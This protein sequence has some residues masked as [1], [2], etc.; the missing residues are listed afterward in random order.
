MMQLRNYQETA[1]TQLNGWWADHDGNP[2]IMLPTGAGKSIVIAAF[3]Q[4]SIALWPKTRIAIICS[5]KEL[6]EQDAAKIKALWPDA[7]MGVVCAA[8]GR[9]EFGR[10]VTVASILSIFRRQ[11]SELGIIDLIVVDEAHLINHKDQGSYRSFIDRQKEVNPNLR[12]IGLTATPYRLGHG[13]ITDGDALFQAPLINP[14]SILDLQRQGYLAMLKSKSTVKK[15]DTDGVA[16]RGGEYVE[17]ELMVKVDDQLTSEQV[18]SETLEKASD[19]KHWLI[20]CCGVEHAQHVRDILCENGVS[21]ACVTGET[22]KKERETLLE[23]F[24]NGKIRALTN[25][26]VLTT[27]FDFPGIDLIVMM[28]PTMS[29]GLYMQ[30]AGRGLRPC[31]GKADCLV[32]DFAGNVSMHGPI[33]DVVPPKSKGNRRT[34]VAPS[35]ICP[36]CDEIIAA[37]AMTCPECGYVF[38]KEVMK[39]SLHDDD[40]MGMEP[41]ELEVEEWQ[42]N[43]ATSRSGV[44]MLVCRFYPVNLA[45]PVMA[46]FYCLWHE[47][48]AGSKALHA[49]YETARH[50]G[51]DIGVCNTPEEVCNTLTRSTPPETITYKRQGKFYNVLDQKWRKIHEIP[52]T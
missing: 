7:P 35:K 28:R 18:I 41:Q 3:C 46:K 23:D 47:S 13:Y 20:F 9:K 17:H 12:V 14:A 5:Q 32:L 1:L 34:G 50:A 30:M 8:T 43:Q 37:S 29:P 49:L 33:T 11:Q 16:I 15:I 2:C 31:E 6:V 25:A 21:C 44:P 42:W 51:A 40:I 19:R 22:P 27:G 26:N 38:P 36:Q 10:Q 24:K 4:R 39:W 45:A 48:Y 52:R